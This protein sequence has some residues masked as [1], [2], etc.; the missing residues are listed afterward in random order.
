[1]KFIA[2]TSQESLYDN[3]DIGR[4]T[5]RTDQPPPK[6]ENGQILGKDLKSATAMLRNRYSNIPQP[7]RQKSDISARSDHPARQPTQQR[8]PFQQQL[9]RSLQT[10]NNNNFKPMPQIKSMANND[11]GRL[12]VSGQTP[13]LHC[14]NTN[15]NQIGKMD[16]RMTLRHLIIFFSA[17]LEHAQQH[18]KSCVHCFTYYCCGECRQEHWPKHKEKCI[19]AR[20]VSTTKSILR[21][22]FQS[23]HILNELAIFGTF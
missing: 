5:K 19:Y 8:P 4:P 16:N 17:P 3:V 22:I 1:M 10:T 2:D 12:M 21:S 18:Y 14:R 15:C 9:P 7:T 11:N 23:Q 13:M 20:A 6:L